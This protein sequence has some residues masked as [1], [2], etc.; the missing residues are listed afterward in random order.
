MEKY[1]RN[2]SESMK[3]KLSII[4]AALMILTVLTGCASGENSADAMSSEASFDYG[5][6][7]EAGA[8]N[9]EDSVKT[10]PTRSPPEKEQTTPLEQKQFFKR[11]QSPESGLL[12]VK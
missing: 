1:F 7:G 2:G 3:K 12:P 9:M 10:S 5:G 4:L 6:T 8:E 11:G